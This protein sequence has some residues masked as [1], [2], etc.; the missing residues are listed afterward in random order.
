MLINYDDD[1][2]E[3]FFKHQRKRVSIIF[4]FCEELDHVIAK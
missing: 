4:F 1:A 2:A 3:Q